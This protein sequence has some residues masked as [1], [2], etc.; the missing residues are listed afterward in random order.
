MLGAHEKQSPPFG[1]LCFS[2]PGYPA[3][4]SFNNQGF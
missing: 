4:E 3:T 2:E 1:G